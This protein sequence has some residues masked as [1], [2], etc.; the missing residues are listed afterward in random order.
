MS[1]EVV[2]LAET[3]WNRPAVTNPAHSSHSVDKKAGHQPRNS[4]QNA[5]LRAYR[6]GR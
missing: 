2:F 1:V 6:N 5:S 3:Q 4:T